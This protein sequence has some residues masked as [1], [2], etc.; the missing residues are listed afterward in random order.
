MYWFRVK[1][2]ISGLFLASVAMCSCFV[3]TLAGFKAPPC[4]SRTLLKRR[5]P[6]YLDWV[7]LS[8]VPQRQQNY[9]GSKTSWAEYGVTYGFVSPPQLFVSSF[10]PVRRRLPQGMAVFISPRASGPP[11]VGRTQDL[12]GSWGVHTVSL[13]RSPTPVGPV[14]LTLAANSVLSP[15]PLK[16]KTPTCQESRGSI[17]RL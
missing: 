1:K 12:P 8:S 9:E 16:V 3:D 14:G 7:R 17:A 10:A 11:R 5:S 2:A 13:P 6:P 15:T 4:C